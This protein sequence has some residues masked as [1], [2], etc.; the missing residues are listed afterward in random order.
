MVEENSDDVLL[1]L[2]FATIIVNAATDN[3]EEALAPLFKDLDEA[4]LYRIAKG[5]DARLSSV[6]DDKRHSVQLIAEYWWQKR[7][8]AKH[9][10]LTL[11]ATVAAVVS[12]SAAI[13]VLLA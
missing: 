3:L 10:R 11:I 2:G 12:A 6:A 7:Q 1:K 5:D 8:T 4:R 9:V 13:V